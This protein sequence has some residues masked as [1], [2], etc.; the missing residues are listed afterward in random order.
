MVPLGK[1]GEAAGRVRTAGLQGG[2]RVRKQKVNRKKLWK[3]LKERRATWTSLTGNVTPV[4]SLYGFFSHFSFNATNRCLQAT[5]DNPRDSEK[6]NVGACGS[7][8]QGNPG[9]CKDTRTATVLD[10][11]KKPLSYHFLLGGLYFGLQSSYFICM[12]LSSVFSG[13]GSQLSYNEW[14]ELVTVGYL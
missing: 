13:K 10:H 12:A 4:S 7:A 6:M 1:N 11:V 8:N 3:E 2:L 5:D 14:N 9:K